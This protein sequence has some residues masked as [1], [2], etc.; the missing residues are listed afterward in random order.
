MVTKVHENEFVGIVGFGRIGGAFGHRLKHAK[1]N[2]I[3]YD[4]NESAQLAARQ[5]GINIANSLEELGERASVIFL[6]VPAGNIVDNVL[7]ILSKVVKKTTIIIDAGNS[8]FNDSIKNHKMLSQIGI[9]FLDCGTSGGIQGLETGFCLMIGGEHIIY[10][11]VEP[12]FK[13]LAA[14]EGYALVGPPGAGHYVKMVHNG[15][16]YALLQGYAEGFHIMKDG[17]FKNLDLALIAHLWEHGSVIR[18]FILEL[19]A[20]IFD[21]IHDFSS[22]SGKVAQSGMGQ[23]TANEAEKY[24]VPATLIEDSIEIRNLSQQ[25]GG[26]FATKLVALLRNK[27]GGHLAEGCKVCEK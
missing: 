12:L 11:K 2:V 1:K 6:V 21:E 17:Q 5:I 18:S 7:K 27:F 19:L 10:K 26:N 9:A 15:I 23:W 22:I 8:N 13:L 24:Q 3:I 4:P 20:D 25:T 14:P 16:E